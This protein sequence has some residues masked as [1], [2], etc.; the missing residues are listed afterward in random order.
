MRFKGLMLQLFLLL[1]LASPVLADDLKDNTIQFDTKRIETEQDKQQGNE[2]SQLISGLFDKKSND[3]MKDVQKSK[4]KAQEKQRESLFQ[5]SSI[6]SR[7][8][9]T[10]QLFV[11]RDQE[12]AKAKYLK[13][14][15]QIEETRNYRPTVLYLTLIVLILIVASLLS[16]KI[17]ENDEEYTH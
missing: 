9:Q 17:R 8:S 14:D 1:F 7:Q 3:K 13:S 15:T 10:K 6:N 5:K 12:Q 2:Q 16:M 4:E 11:S